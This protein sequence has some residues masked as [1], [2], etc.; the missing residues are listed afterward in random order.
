MSQVKVSVEVGSSRAAVSGATFVGAV[1]GNKKAAR[2]VE[3]T[4]LQT[5]NRKHYRTKTVW[6]CDSAECLKDAKALTKA[7]TDAH[8][9][10]VAIFLGV[11]GLIFIVGSQDKKTEVA[12]VAI[13]DVPVVQPSFLPNK[14]SA[15]D[16]P[17]IFSP[18]L[19][20]SSP[21]QAIINQ[22]F[23]ELRRIELDRIKDVFF[24]VRNTDRIRIQSA[25]ASRGMY[26]GTV[27][28]LWGTQTENAI[29]Q[30]VEEYI[31][32]T[33]GEGWPSSQQEIVVI[34]DSL[35]VDE[36]DNQSSN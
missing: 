20:D 29:S 35:V 15:V 5:S 23:F 16:E 17:A 1:L 2:A 13:S 19:E 3:R 30:Y 7:S 36:S 9:L 26:I 18:V 8:P 31:L 11:V 22:E 28:G 32:K 14:T 4:V 33:N 24:K 25:L 27:D 21:E 12:V 6:C 10:V 34:F